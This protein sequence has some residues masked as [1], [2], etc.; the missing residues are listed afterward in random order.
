MNCY[1]RIPRENIG[2]VGWM[3]VMAIVFEHNACL[4]KVYCNHVN[5]TKGLY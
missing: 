5:F 1:Y 3:S 4:I 2:Y